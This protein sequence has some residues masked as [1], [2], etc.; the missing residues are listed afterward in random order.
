[1]HDSQAFTPS[2]IHDFRVNQVLSYR[3]SRATDLVT[4]IPLQL[5]F[6]YI[7][8]GDQLLGEII[9]YPST[10]IQPY[11]IVLFSKSNCLY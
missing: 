4:V 8:A 6:M 7:L 11:L 9:K 1:M 3:N 2:N 5:T 10:W